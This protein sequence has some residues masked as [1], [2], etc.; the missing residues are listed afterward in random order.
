MQR[1]N[2]DLQGVTQ[3]IAKLSSEFAFASDQIAETWKDEKARSFLQRH[4]S[5]VG[6]T[7][8][9]LVSAL[10]KTIEAYEDIAKR[11]QDPD[12]Y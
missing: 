1:K 7:V 12:R 4:T 8:N 9:L 5:E 3:R 6:P 2:H 11:L 10:T